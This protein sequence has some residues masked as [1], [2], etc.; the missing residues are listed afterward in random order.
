MPRKSIKIDVNPQVMKWARESAGADFEALQ[1]RLNVSTKTIA[2]WEEGNKKPTLTTLQKLA[3]YYKRPLAIFFLPEPPQEP[4]L[5]RDF[6]VLPEGQ[7]KPLS[8]KARRAIRRA[9]RV[10]TL[11]TE[12]MEMDPDKGELKVDVGKLTTRDNAEMIATSE[13]ER[14]GITVDKQ[15]KFKNSYEAFDSWRKALESL[16]VVVYQARLPVNEIRGFSI[17]NHKLPIIVISI[18]DAINARI[19]TLF[20]EYAHILL[21]ISGICIPS[22]SHD[23]NQ[24][25]E[26]FCD[27][28]AGAFLVP[29]QN[30]EREDCARRVHSQSAIDDDCLN[31]LARK[32]KVSNQVILRRLLDCSLTSRHEYSRKLTEILAE[33]EKKLLKKRQKQRYGLAPPK[34]CVLEN[35]RLF[36]S[37]VFEA[38]DRGLITRNDLA[39]YLSINLKHMPK[40]EEYLKK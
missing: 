7:R 24:D 33:Q 37:L 14:I 39:D 19:F 32:F 27:Q 31:E 23:D 11:A 8:M 12:L 1:K 6:R 36:S 29:R 28:F 35:G 15:F 26:R 25:V 4:P 38:R 17:L 3:R 30:L 9:R 20:H 34:R 5:P 10:Q 2:E 13:R 22:E 40:V 18:S 21:G 16:N